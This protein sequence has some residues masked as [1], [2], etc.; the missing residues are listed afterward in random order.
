MWRKIC[1]GEV[2]FH[3]VKDCVRCL[4]TTTDQTI[5]VVG[6]EPLKTLATYRRAQKG[7]I[8][9]QNLI[10][11]HEGII[12]LGDTIEVVEQ[13]ATANFSLRVNDSGTNRTE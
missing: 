3:I 10:H 13:A 9:G 11:A 4:I 12:R 6:K 5:A 8:F 2:A 1:I 7:V